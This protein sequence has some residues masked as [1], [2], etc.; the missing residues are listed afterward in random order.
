[1]VTQNFSALSLCWSNIFGLCF[2][3]GKF[4][5]ALQPQF[6]FFYTSLL[7]LL[8]IPDR[9]MSLLYHSSLMF[10]VY[11][12]F[13]CFH[14]FSFLDR[15]S[16]IPPTLIKFHHQF[17][18]WINSM[19]VTPGSRHQFQPHFGTHQPPIPLSP[20]LTRPGIFCYRNYS[21]ASHKIHPTSSL[22][23]LPRT[24]M[25]A[26]HPS[27]QVSQSKIQAQFIF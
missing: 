7:A 2:H 17:H 27:Q 4:L 10:L 26:H 19:L 9:P 14:L 12:C 21:K 1:M 24:L 25:H 5:V 8:Q 22:T 18:A 3:C 11:C 20:L 23:Q 15:F 13:F 16:T 6:H